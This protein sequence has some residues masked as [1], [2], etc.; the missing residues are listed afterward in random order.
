MEPA[1]ASVKPRVL[2]KDAK[3]RTLVRAAG[4]VGTMAVLAA[5]SS[6][7]SRCPAA[8]P[9]IQFVEPE[10]A[11][12][13]GAAA[14]PF[15]GGAEAGPTRRDAVPGYVELSG[16]LKVPGH[17][18]TTRAKR[19]KIYNLR[20]KIYEYVPVP[21]CRS[22]EAVVEWARMQKQWRF[23]EAGSPEKVF[24]GKSYPVRRLAWRLRLRSGHVIVGHILGQPLYV[25][26]NGKRERF[27]LHKRHK[28]A[29]GETLNDLVFVRRI[30]FGPKAYNEAVEEL[31][32]KAH[33]AADE[34]ENATGKTAGETP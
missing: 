9:D 11:P 6:A 33:Q 1:K 2:R 20:R 13:G 19:L 21:A 29:L 5:V 23:K 18:Y 24:T 10:A 28:G 3:G 7:A 27:I 34:K 22:I 25:Q 15:A 14:N 16:G 17:I 32:Q 12:P 26:H 30:K 4:L 31:A 8:E